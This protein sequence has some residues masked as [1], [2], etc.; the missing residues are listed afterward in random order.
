MEDVHCCGP[1][2]V[3]V[4]EHACVICV[5][6]ARTHARTRVRTHARTHAYARTHTVRACVRARVCRGGMDSRRA[7]TLIL[8]VGH[9][10]AGTIY[11]TPSQC[12]CDHDKQLRQTRSMHK[13]LPDYSLEEGPIVYVYSSH[14]AILMYSFCKDRLKSFLYVATGIQTSSPENCVATT[15]L[16]FCCM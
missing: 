6:H 3:H 9:P 1:V 12:A 7:I 5:C 15:R 14:F 8:P 10:P 16:T 11:P 13:R 4:C 2:C